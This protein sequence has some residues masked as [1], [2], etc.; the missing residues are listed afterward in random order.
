M[1]HVVRP[2]ADRKIAG[3]CAGFAQAYGWDVTVV[4]LVALL[5][6]FCG[7]GG[8]ALAYVIAWVVIPNETVGTKTYPVTQTPPT[9]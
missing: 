1:R 5:L 8:G 7:V 6:L 4:R 9:A 3:V 2:L